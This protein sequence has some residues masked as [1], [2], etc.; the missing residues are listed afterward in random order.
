MDRQLAEQGAALD[1]I[2]YCPD[3]PAGDDRTIVENP[4]ASRGPA[5]C[6]GPPTT[7]PGPAT[8]WMVGDLISDVLA[9]LNAGCR[10]SW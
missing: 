5:C 4:T 2:Y 9:G 6:S 8:S 10:A 1:A 3:V 7:W